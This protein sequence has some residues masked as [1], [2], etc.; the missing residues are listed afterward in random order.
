[1]STTNQ[2]EYL[3]DSPS[4]KNIRNIT[5]PEGV[6]IPVELASFWDRAGAFII[7]FVILLIPPILILGLMMLIG[8]VGGVGGGTR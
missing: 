4:S 6:L 2:A 3:F 5:T 7:D 1:M 8:G